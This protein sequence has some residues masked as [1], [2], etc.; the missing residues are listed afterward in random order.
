M[1][2][3]SILMSVYK[4]ENPEYLKLSIESMLNQTVPSDD[5]VIVEDG[6]LTDELYG[7]LN[8]YEKTAACIHRHKLSENVGL[9]KALNEGLK[10]CR[11]ELV[12]RMDS[13]DIS[14]LQ[15]CEKQLKC[16]ENDKEL[17]I[18]GTDLLEFTDDPEKP[19]SLKCQP[20]T[21]KEIYRFG[22]R[23]N[24]FNH[25]TVMY[26]KSEVLKAGGYA[27]YRRGQDIELFNRMV[28][29]KIKCIN[30]SEPLLKYRRNPNAVKRRKDW[31]SVKRIIQVIYHSWKRGY[32]GLGDLIY[33]IV[34]E[35]AI[36]VLPIKVT[37]YIYMHY[38]RKNF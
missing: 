4:K 14:E 35:F 32:S 16:F 8:Y 10:V 30:I 7:V 22:R 34:T 21:S 13:D 5:F 3:Y 11:N 33:V 6:P 20:G 27:D 25:P 2:N 28:G 24:P 29:S 18:V 26:K 19:V 9:G 36:F 1:S 31:G 38:F 17:V 37:N 12:A 23:R 15:R